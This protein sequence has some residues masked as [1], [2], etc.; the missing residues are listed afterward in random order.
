MRYVCNNAR[1]WLMVMETLGNERGKANTWAMRRPSKPGTPPAIKDNNHDDF[2]L[3]VSN[4]HQL[5]KPCEHHCST[6]EETVGG[7]SKGHTFAL[8]YNIMQSNTTAL[9]HVFV[10]LITIFVETS[11]WQCQ[12]FKNNSTMVTFELMVCLVWY[13]TAVI[14]KRGKKRSKIIFYVL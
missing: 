10:Q 14:P 4:Y 9:Q 13:C 12:K 7:H 2:D 3:R 1:H 6:G 5:R 11:H 8:H